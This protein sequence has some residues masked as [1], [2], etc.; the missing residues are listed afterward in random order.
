MGAEPS[1]EVLIGGLPIAP[2]GSGSFDSATVGAK[3]INIK[4]LWCVGDFAFG[5]GEVV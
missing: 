4:R 5:V 1:F 2:D 3:I